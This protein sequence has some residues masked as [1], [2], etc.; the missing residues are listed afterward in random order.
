MTKQDAPTTTDAERAPT[1]SEAAR[2][3]RWY[4]ADGFAQGTKAPHKCGLQAVSELQILV[5]ENATLRSTLDRVGPALEEWFAK[6]E[7]V[8]KT[9]QPTELGKHIADVLRER[10]AAQSSQ[11]EAARASSAAAQWLPI[12]TAP[13]DGT[14]I[15]G[16]TDVGALVLYWD[17]LS[18]NPERWSDGMSRYHRIPTH[19]MPLPA[20]PAEPADT[21]E[22][23][24]AA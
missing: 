19:W 9:I 20:P 2:L 10:L 5:A 24:D 3:C 7:W 16:H 11:D 13:K 15:L 6:T 18:D 12:E 17:T 4:A 22:A 21:G 23:P 8:R 14:E 1:D